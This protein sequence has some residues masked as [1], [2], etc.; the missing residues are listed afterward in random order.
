MLS[1]KNRGQTGCFGVAP[2]F[3][4][5]YAEAALVFQFIIDEDAVEES[6]Q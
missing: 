5:L 3:L 4:L 2:I 1:G 6:L